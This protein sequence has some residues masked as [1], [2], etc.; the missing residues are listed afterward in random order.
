MK[1]GT[2]ETLTETL[3]N[4]KSGFHSR[5]FGERSGGKYTDIHI[6]KISEDSKRAYQQGVSASAFNSRQMA[7]YRKPPYP[8]HSITCK[9]SAEYLIQE[10][11]RDAGVRAKT[12][13]ATGLD[14]KCLYEH[15]ERHIHNSV[16]E[17]YD[18]IGWDY[19]KK[20]FTNE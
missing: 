16:W 2:K 1:V 18:Y 8:Y 17:F 20:K 13:K 4:N 11:E 6:I 3:Q 5:V 7:R 9:G 12:N 10:I 15:C 14:L 19:K